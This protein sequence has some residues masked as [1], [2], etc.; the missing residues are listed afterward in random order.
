MRIRIDHQLMVTTETEDGSF[1]EVRDEGIS[2]ADEI[3]IRADSRSFKFLLRS[4]AR[5]TIWTRRGVELLHRACAEYLR[6]KS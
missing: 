4:D 1:V 5:S 6:G 2:D 3:Q